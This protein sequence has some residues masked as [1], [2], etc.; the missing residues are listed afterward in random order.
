MGQAAHVKALLESKEIILRGELRKRLPFSE[1]GNL[2]ANLDRL[3]FTVDGEPVELILGNDAS[4]KWA[5]SITNP[6]SLAKKLGITPQSI[7]RVIG[8]VSE[9]SLNEALAQAAQIAEKNASLIIAVADSLDSLHHALKATRSQWSKG[10]PIWIVYPK[11]KGHSID[12]TAV[13]SLLRENGLMDTKVASI[14]TRLTALRF[15]LPKNLHES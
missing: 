14:S 6:P 15:S 3:S 13:R 4:A 12:E 7:V 1:L 8:D 11:G 10:V 5:S 9:E 2:K